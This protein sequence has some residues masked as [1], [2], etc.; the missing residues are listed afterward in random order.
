MFDFRAGASLTYT[1]EYQPGPTFSLGES[2]QTTTV[3]GSA[4]LVVRFAPGSGVD[5]SGPEFVQTYTGPES[6]RPSGLTHVR[7][8]RRISDFEAVLIW[9]IGLDGEQPFTVGVLDGPPRLYIDVA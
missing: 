9:V 6:I 4:F 2:D 5:L 8:I 7:E 3:E 1:V